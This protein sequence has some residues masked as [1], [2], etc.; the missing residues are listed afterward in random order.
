MVNPSTH[1]SWLTFAIRKNKNS[2][3]LERIAGPVN[4]EMVA[5]V[6]SGGEWLDLQRMEA[7]EPLRNQLRNIERTR[8]K[9]S[10]L[11]VARFAIRMIARCDWTHI[12]PLRFQESDAERCHLAKPISQGR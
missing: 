8:L 9:L 10:G 4:D 11:R 3:Q 12:D 1:Q 5:R 6:E 7:Y 2:L